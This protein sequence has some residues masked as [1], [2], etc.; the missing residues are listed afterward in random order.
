MKR[1]GERNNKDLK[2][3]SII[4][5]ATPAIEMH[6]YAPTSNELLSSVEKNIAYFP[7]NL[8]RFQDDGGISPP[9]VN[10]SLH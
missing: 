10:I 9:L 3:L 5:G 6:V 4:P 2:Q 8:L 1:T 7:K